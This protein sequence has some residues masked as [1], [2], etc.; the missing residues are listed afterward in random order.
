MNT[1]SHPSYTHAPNA[2]VTVNG[3]QLAYRSVGQGQPLVLCMRFRGTMDA[4]DPAFIDALV[5][6]GYRVITFDYSGL[7]LSSGTPNYMPTALA[8]DAKA[9]IDALQLR[10]VV[11]GGWS[12]GG[13]AVQVAVAKYADRISHAFMIGAVPPGPNVRGA[14]PLFNATAL[15]EHN[16]L[17]DEVVLFFEPASAASRAAAARSH[18]RLALRTEDRCPPVPWA[19]ATA[20]LSPVPRVPLFPADALLPALQH[21]R[22]PL[23]HLGGDHDIAF[24]VEN[25]YAVQAS[26]PTLQ[27][28]TLPQAGHGPHHQYP[29]LAAQ[30]IGAFVKA[31]S[32]QGAST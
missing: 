19:V 12:V 1:V 14:E 6:Q 23:L 4:W 30:Y 5:A 24:P 31:T 10:N 25:W 2:W 18:A 3:R 27:L 17:E 20:T 29:E 28:V 15:K 22:V 8:D 16:D 32:R 13:L 26:M 21:T 9:L 11:L 7:G